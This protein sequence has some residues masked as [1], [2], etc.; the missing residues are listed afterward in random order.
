MGSKKDSQVGA[1]GGGG[2]GLSE[3]GGGDGGGGDGGGDGGGG[4]GGG[5]AI[6]GT[7]GLD[8][9]S[10]YETSWTLYDVPYDDLSMRLGR[11]LGYDTL[12][13]SAIFLRPDVPPAARQASAS[14]TL[15]AQHT[16]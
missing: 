13:F 11:A 2:E 4:D 6:G 5:G 15:V 12:F 14:P 10:M 7:G 8:G 1:S 9:G 3:G 16:L